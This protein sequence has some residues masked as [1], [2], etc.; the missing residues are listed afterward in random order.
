[1]YDGD[2]F[3]QF[4]GLQQ[5]I[6]PRSFIATVFYHKQLGKVFATMGSQS[7]HEF[8]PDRPEL[9]EF[10]KGRWIQSKILKEI[11]T[12]RNLKSG[13]RIQGFRYNGISFIKKS[14]TLPNC[15]VLSTGGL[16]AS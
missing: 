3:H 5:H 2:R 9:F 12:I 1:M 14:K 8:N 4:P 7:P 10:N 11:S 16:V 6:R 15:L 13:Q